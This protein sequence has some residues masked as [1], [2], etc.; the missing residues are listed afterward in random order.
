MNKLPDPQALL[1]EAGMEDMGGVIM[2]GRGIGKQYMDACVTL[3][4]KNWSFPA[5]TQW[6]EERGVTLSVHGW[7][8][9]YDVHTG[10]K[11]HTKKK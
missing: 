7:R 11:S 8:S 4:E 10:R 2:P 5:I 6:M 3:R 1:A 9:A